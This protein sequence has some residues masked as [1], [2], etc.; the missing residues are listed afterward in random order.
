MQF[1]KKQIIFLTVGGVTAFILALVALDML[2]G[3]NY[4]ENI[5]TLTFWGV[6][7]PKIWAKTITNFRTD[8]P[9]LA[10]S[11]KRISEDNYE[12]ELVNAMALG[13]GPDIFM[14]ENNWLLKHGDKVAPAPPGKMTT[15]TVKTLFPQVAEDDFLA[16][17]QV[18]ALPLY[19]DTLAMVYNRTLFDQGEIVFPPKTW[20]EVALAT[21]AL[22]IVEGDTIKRG[23]F[24]LGGS[25]RNIVNAADIVSA[26]F[27]QNG[28]SMVNKELNRSTFSDRKGKDAFS[29]YVRFADPA[30]SSYT[31]NQSL[32]MDS[33]ALVRGEV[34]AIFAYATEAQDLE[35]RNSF[36]DIGVAPLPQ[37]DPTDEVSMAD[38]WGLAVSGRSSHKIKGK[39]VNTTREAWDF[40]IFATTN[41]DA[42]STYMAHTGRPPALRT[43]INEIIATN[44][45]TAAAYAVYKE[46][47]PALRT[48]IDKTIANPKL[49][50]FASQALTA[51]S[52]LR[53]GEESFAEAFD[54]AVEATLNGELAAPK[55]L[56][57][58]GGIITEELQSR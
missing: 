10:I 29:I 20:N 48:V 24:A 53:L 32:H 58:A 11:Y 45:N 8:R 41:E 6:D 3:L 13:K 15:D 25:S 30:S 37:I 31:W 35:D 47:R 51:R 40:V 14:F 22:K 7:D 55:A 9:D 26:F 36:L 28:N 18:Y 50:I 12:K 5:T 49:G 27:L 19:I 2:P 38:Y 57:R 17:N 52:W 34:A 21:S 46:R 4:K 43:L 39:M 54:G 1:T 44:E 16:N 33:E 42:A 23:A 56:D